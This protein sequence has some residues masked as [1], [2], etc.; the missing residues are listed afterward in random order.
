MKKTSKNFVSPKAIMIMMNKTVLT[1]PTYDVN[2]C[3]PSCVNEIG[4]PKRS[5]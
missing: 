4:L 1:A 2:I 3:L 5:S